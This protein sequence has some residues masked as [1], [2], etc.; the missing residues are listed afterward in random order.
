MLQLVGRAAARRWRAPGWRSP[1]DR[2]R[3]AAPASRRCAP[4]RRAAS[5]RCARGCGS[6]TSTT[7]WLHRAAMASGRARPARAAPGV[8]AGRP[9]PGSPSFAGTRPAAARSSSICI[10]VSG[11]AVRLE[12]RARTATARVLASSMR[13]SAFAPVPRACAG[14]DELRAC[15][16]TAVV[17]EA[18]PAC[19]SPRRAACRSRP[20]RRPRSA[21]PVGLGR[22]RRCGR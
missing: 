3:A 21:P 11:D 8:S 1:C 6:V 5:R 13:W 20:R 18:R 14:D 12:R 17:G 9:R 7:A 16:L 2:G 22:G 10:R 4:G 15:R 19:S